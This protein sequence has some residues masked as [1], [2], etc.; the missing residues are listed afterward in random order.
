M[1]RPKLQRADWLLLGVLVVG[2]AVMALLST[3]TLPTEQE[4]SPLEVRSTFYNDAAGVKAAY[5]VL[6]KLGYQTQRLRR[7]I[8]AHRLASL[9]GL[10][11]LEPMM[12]PLSDQEQS[13]MLDWVA[14]GHQLLIVPGMVGFDDWMNTNWVADGSMIILD[15]NAAASGKRTATAGDELVDGH[16]ATRGIQK[17]ATR[18]RMRFDSDAPLAGPLE[19][20]TAHV[21]WSDQ[22]GVVGLDVEFGRGRIL[23]LGDAYPLSNIGLGQAD[24]DLLLANLAAI[25][26]G[27]EGA[28]TIG[29]D[30][31][32]HGFVERDTSGMA[33]AKL[34]FSE[35]RRWAAV[36]AIAVAVLALFA[37]AVRFGRPR[38]IVQ[39]PR[40][41]DSEFIEAAARLLDDADATH[42]VQTTLYTHYRQ[43]LCRLTHLEDQATD[44][45]LADVVARQTG[46]RIGYALR[47]G[48]PQPNDRPCPRSELL[49]MCRTLQQSV[50]SLEHGSQTSDRSHHGHS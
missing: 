12:M 25:L 46:L 26:T 31:F 18:P 27:R 4:G 35:R 24:N 34:I 37:L 41:R 33:I 3:A 17:L 28:G 2:G 19:D 45:A 10:A 6:R 47:I 16:E 14:A 11:V 38:D 39:R 40:R 5:L 36:Q 42:S 9:D 15:E 22:S 48:R 20:Q 44:E 29:F 30:E 23:M 13:E 43:R 8:T 21:F 1:R 50:E 49:D 32:H 7:P